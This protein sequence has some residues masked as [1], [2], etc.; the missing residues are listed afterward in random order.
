MDSRFRLRAR[1]F[2]WAHRGASRIAPENT[3]AAFN[4]AAAQGA[5]GIELDAQL[6]KSGEVVVFHDTTL[7][8]VAGYPG[9]LEEFTWS[10]LQSFD[11]GSRKAARWAGERIPLLSEVFDATPKHLVVNVE[12]KCDRADD[13]GLTKRVIETVRAT[14]ATERVLLS[15]FNP[16]C[17]A[18]ARALAPDLPRALLFEPDSTWWLR[19]ARSAA[20]LDLVALHPAHELATPE[21]VARWRERYTLACWT[22]DDLQLARELWS[23]GISGLITNTPAEL[24]ALFS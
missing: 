20:L 8:R 17:L 12:L 7:A 9:L 22:V 23:R 16:L 10:E 3:L 24:L 11:L 15:S 13:R 2:I 6:C 5:D 21:R 4:L 14:C 18:R 1:P 19:T